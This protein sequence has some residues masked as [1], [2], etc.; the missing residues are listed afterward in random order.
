[1]TIKYEIDHFH[2]RSPD[3]ENSAR[4]YVEMLNATEVGRAEIRGKLR[5]TVKLGDL[6]FFIEEVPSNTPAPPTPPF[7]GIEHFGLQVDDIDAAATDLR[8]R[9]VHFTTEPVESRPGVRMAF[10]EGPEGVRI[11]LIERTSA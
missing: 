9:G 4:F 2:L 1:M 6:Q 8:A 10:I 5:I 11:E 7:L 3:P